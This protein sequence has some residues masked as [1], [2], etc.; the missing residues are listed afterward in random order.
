MKNKEKARKKKTKNE[1]KSLMVKFKIKSNN[2]S[3]QIFQ[4][5]STSSLK[6]SKPIP[7]L[8]VLRGN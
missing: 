5:S 2:K 6:V 1:T 3:N 8:S 4:K 7:M